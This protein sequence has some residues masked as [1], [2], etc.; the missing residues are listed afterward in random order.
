LPVGQAA[1]LGSM[2]DRTF[3]LDAIARDARSPLSLI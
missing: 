1:Q 3:R 2:P